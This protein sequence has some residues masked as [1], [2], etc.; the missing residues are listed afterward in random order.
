MRY[1]GLLRGVAV[2][3][4]APSERLSRLP[5]KRPYSQIILYILFLCT[6]ISG[7]MSWSNYAE[8]RQYCSV[9]KVPMYYYIATLLV[10]IHGK[11]Q[12]IFR[13][14]SHLD[15]RCTGLTRIVYVPGRRATKSDESAWIPATNCKLVFCGQSIH[16][17]D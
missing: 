1:P 3:S 15:H 5:R 13:L 17:F 12:P 14:R 4:I 11:L 9:E 16:W 2:H 7:T 8:C 6:Y 10:F